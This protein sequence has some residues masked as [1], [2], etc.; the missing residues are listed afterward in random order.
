MEIKA[1]INRILDPDKG[2]PTPWIT[3]AAVALG[4]AIGVFIIIKKK[5]SGD[6]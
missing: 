1:T 4:G 3:L 2:N 5:K 6:Q